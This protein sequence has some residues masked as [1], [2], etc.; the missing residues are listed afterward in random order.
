MR[1]GTEFYQLPLCF[2]TVLLQQEVLQF[3]EEEWTA[4]PDKFPGNSALILISANGSINDDFALSGEMLPTSFLRRCPYI[5]QV[6]TSLQTPLSRTRLMRV[7]AEAEVPSHTDTHHYWHQRIRIHIP[8]IT[9]PSV[10]FICNEKAVHMGA[11]QVWIFD[12]TKTHRVTNP[13]D[14]PRIHLVTDTKGS[15]T[16]CQLIEQSRKPFDAASKVE[17]GQ[18]QFV[19][20]VPDASCNLPLEPFKFEVFRPE[21]LVSFTMEIL[22]EA[23]AHNME[24]SK[25][26]QLSEHTQALNQRWMQ[27]FVRHGH[28]ETGTKDYLHALESFIKNIE[29]DNLNIG[30][31]TKDLLLTFTSLAKELRSLMDSKK[32]PHTLTFKA[33]KM[34]FHMD[35]NSTLQISSN[36]QLR[37]T[38]QGWELKGQSS[39]GIGL[40]LS[41]TNAEIIGAFK[42]PSTPSLAWKHLQSK[43]EVSEADYCNIVQ[44][45]IALRFLSEIP[46][47]PTFENPIFIVSA[48]RSGSGMLFET[49]LQADNLWT[50]GGESHH[51]IERIPTLHP[52]YRSFDSNRLT[53]DEVTP[54]IAR[55]LHQYFTHELQ[56]N[57]GKLFI[58]LPACDRP[59]SLRFLEKTPKNSLRIPFLKAIFPDARF[60]YLYREPEESIS[61]IIDAWRSGQFVTYRD[62]PNWNLLPWSLL[63]PPDWTY[64]QGK[65]LEEVAAFQWKSANMYILDD[66]QSV[67]KQEWCFVRY[68]DLLTDTK[69]QLARLCRFAGIEWTNRFEN[70]RP[71]SLP[72]STTTLSPP[73]PNKWRRHEKLIYSVLPHLEEVKARIAQISY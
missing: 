68:A 38:N 37:S 23:K 14:T 16:L 5:Q 9:D 10:E 41:A 55:S 51:I 56:D 48:P 20:Y 27:T 22:L 49:L 1:L 39:E 8:I 6:L 52:A 29:Q 59:T 69:D 26:V 57:S 2:D 34:N 35:W 61:S 3:T 70:L 21:E 71:Y 15:P 30:H 60:I 50:V 62:L 12:T 47:C 53:A 58:D 44:K 4:H 28:N 25:F 40:K 43:S 33:G 54:E 11:G 67:P 24:P 7:G 45:F 46:T 19:P 66:L 73:D 36:V 63:L 64:L 13:S 31:V 18:M 42:R 72:L 17:S 65:P 32:L